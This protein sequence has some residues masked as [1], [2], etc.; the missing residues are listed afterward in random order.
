VLAGD[1]LMAAL[2]LSELVLRLVPRNDAQPGLFLRF[3]RA[4]DEL[5]E[6]SSL[7]WTLRRFERDLL[8]ELGYALDLSQDAEAAPL[9]ANAR[10]RIDPEHGALRIRDSASTNRSG[11]GGE[12]LLSLAREGIPDP[13]QLREQRLALRAVIAHHLGARGLR[14]WGLLAEFAGLKRGPSADGAGQVAPEEERPT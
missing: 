11:I 2:Y 1:A 4:L 14:S 6:T 5:A 7:A 8:D 3:A 9:E 13:V 10:Y 12:A